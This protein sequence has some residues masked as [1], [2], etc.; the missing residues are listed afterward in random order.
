M[1][2]R[3][4][5]RKGRPYSF[6]LQPQGLSDQS[7]NCEKRWTTREYILCETHHSLAPCPAVCRH[8]RLA[9][10]IWLIACSFDGMATLAGRIA[11]L[12]GLVAYFRAHHGGA[13]PAVPLVGVLFR[14]AGCPKCALY[15]THRADDPDSPVGP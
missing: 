11:H 13:L 14:F 3:D 7:V 9:Q 6:D 10:F 12:A 15:G 4:S 5:F 2:S 1:P 8:H